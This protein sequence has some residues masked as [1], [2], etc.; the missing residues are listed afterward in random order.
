M[1]HVAAH[2]QVDRRTRSQHREVAET[3]EVQVACAAI[4][5]DGVFTAVES[6]ITQL[7]PQLQQR[8]APH[9]FSAADVEHAA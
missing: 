9:A 6:E 7:R 3:G 2:Q 8:C 5:R 1:Q 4:A